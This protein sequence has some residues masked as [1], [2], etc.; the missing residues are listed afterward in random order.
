MNTE[1]SRNTNSIKIY[2]ELTYIQTFDN[3]IL[4]IWI[5]LEELL[6]ML[7]SNK[8]LKLWNRILNTSNVKNA[9]T[10]KADE[11]DNAIL[12]IEDKELRTRV[13][14]EIDKRRKDWS[15]VNIEVY[16]NILNRLSK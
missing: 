1:N 4:P 9:F 14:T 13:Q 5:S 10:K 7:N 2:K 3:D 12:Q 8:F 16:Q 11:V 15:R 6:G